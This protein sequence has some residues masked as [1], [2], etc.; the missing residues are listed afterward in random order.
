MTRAR[1]CN[2]LNQ[3]VFTVFAGSGRMPAR[4]MLG[5]AHKGVAVWGLR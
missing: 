4:R 2:A 3:N 5:M 1:R